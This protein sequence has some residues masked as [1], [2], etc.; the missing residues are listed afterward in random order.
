M[1]MRLLGA[2]L[3]IVVATLALTPMTVSAAQ[4]CE[5]LM[6]V[7]LADATITGA[8]AVPAGPWTPPAVAGAPGP[9]GGPRPIELPAFCRVQVTVNPSIKIEV[10]MPAAGWNGNF[11][12]V[13]N[14]GYAGNIVYAAMAGALRGGYATANTDTGHT[15]TQVDWALG[16]GAAAKQRITDFGYRAVH[17]MTVKAKQLI[18]AFYGNAPKISYFNGCSTGG[19]QAMT[20][21]QRYPEDFN[22]IYAGAPAMNWSLQ[23]VSHVYVGLATTKDEDSFVPPA[24]LIALQNAAV[25]ECDMLDGVKDGLIADPRRCKFD[26]AVLLCKGADSP[27]C[28]TAKQVEAIKKVYAPLDDPKGKRLYPGHV[29]GAESG[30]DRFLT[31]AGPGK[32]LQL[33]LGVSYMRYFVLQD[34]NWDYKTWDFARD[35]PKV[36][37]AWTRSV[38]DSTNPDLK[39][40]RDKGGK[41]IL[42]Q[43]WGDDTVSPLNTVNYY[44]GVVTKLT[45]VGKGTDAYTPEDAA[46]DKAAEQTGNFFRMFMVPGMNHCGGGPGPNNFDGFTSLVK[47]VETKQAPDSIIATHMTNNMPDRTRPLC[48]FPQTAQYTGSGSIDDASN[49]A[50]RLPVSGAGSN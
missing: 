41:L 37:S 21:A 7:K 29:P 44:K 38:V 14:N 19:R 43:G 28:L 18:E 9:P 39:P 22:G 13:G 40:F 27:S 3:L 6:S 45:G 48:P 10:W 46:F 1:K 34:P 2:I 30:W 31:G 16:T 26:P 36:E 32:G 33:D 35:L 47:W 12:A 24:K 11:E 5:S 15:N 8:A 42:Y 20:E 50:C 23:M 4:S 17:E 25:E 49:F